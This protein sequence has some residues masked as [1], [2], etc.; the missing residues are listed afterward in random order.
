[1]IRLP[2]ALVTRGPFAVIRH[3]F[4]VAYSLAWLAAPVATHGPL[5]TLFSLVA[6]GSYVVA[7]RPRERQLEGPIRRGV[8]DL[9]A[10]HRHGGAVDRQALR[11]PMILHYPQTLIH[12][13]LG[14][15]D[16]R[17]GRVLCRGPHGVFRARAQARR[18]W[19]SI[20]YLSMILALAQVAATLFLAPRADAF[21]YAA[22]VMHLSAIVLYLGAIEAAQRTRLQRSFIDYP[23]PDRLITE[24]PFRWV[25]HPFCVGYLLGTLAGPIGI[26]NPVA[27]AIAVPM[28]VVVLSAAVRE[29]R[30]WLS[31][32]RAEEY[33]EYRRRTGMFIPF[34]GRG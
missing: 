33:R 28:V 17:R 31:G 22:I 16:G 32:S 3:P 30:V 7:A 34:I 27:L 24:G 15:L 2:R 4:Y 20:H 11:G 18:G 21:V 23:L 13:L 9:P 14:G 19:W 26:A 10:R 8:S 12:W 29:E 5:I 25:R 6:I 1:M